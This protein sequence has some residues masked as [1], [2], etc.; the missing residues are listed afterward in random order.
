M[1]LPGVARWHHSEDLRPD[2][3]CVVVHDTFGGYF[4]ISY[5][6]EVLE[7][8]GKSSSSWFTSSQ[9]ISL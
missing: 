3:N 5:E 2:N 4:P 7:V 1:K 6:L 9:F 8:I